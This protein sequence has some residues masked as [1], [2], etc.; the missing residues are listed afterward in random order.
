M[1]G[2]EYF[3]ERSPFCTICAQNPRVTK[4]IV[5]T[6]VCILVIFFLLYASDVFIAP[7]TLCYIPTQEKNFKSS[8]S[9]S[10]KGTVGQNWYKYSS[11]QPKGDADNVCAKI[12][13]DSAGKQDKHFKH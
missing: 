13:Y 2:F 4:F 1:E 5:F 11:F 3:P 12:L 7:Y 6:G 8:S 9:S 10:V